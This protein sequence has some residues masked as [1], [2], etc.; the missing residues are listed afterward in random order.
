MTAGELSRMLAARADSV[1]RELLPN[2]K[3]DGREW[4]VGSVNGEAGQS[5]GVCIKGDKAGTWK[6]FNTGDGGDLLDLIRAAQGVDLPQACDIARA[7]LGLPSEKLLREPKK[8]YSR[9]KRPKCQAPKSVVKEYLASRGISE[10]TMAAYK[11]GEQGNRMVF[12]F[13]R[14]GELIMAKTREAV[15]GGKTKPTEANCEPCLFGWQAV[16]AKSR[17]LIITEGEIDALSVR[18]MGFPALSVPYGGGGGD[19]QGWIEHEFERLSA[20]DSLYLMLDNDET[21]DQGVAEIVKRLGRDRIRIVRIP[22]PYKDANDLLTKARFSEVDMANLLMRA[23]TLDPAELRAASSYRDQVLGEVEA[24]EA[25]GFDLPWPKTHDTFRMRFGESIIV[26]GVNG[27]GKTELVGNIALSV[28]SQNNRACIASYEFKPQRYLRRFLRQAAAMENPSTPLMSA[29]FDW[30]DDKL[31]MVDAHGKDR[32]QKTLEVF[33][34][35]ARR[36]GVRFFVLDNLS[37][38]GI[39]DDDYQAQKEFIDELSELA[40]E[41]DVVVIIVM[42]MT[43]GDESRPSGKMQARGSGQIT[44]LVDS[45]L[46]VWRNKPKEKAMQVGDHEKS[47]EPDCK[48][49]CEKQRNGEHETAYKLWFDQP[50]HQFKEHPKQF[51]KRYVSIAA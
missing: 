9:P 35:A 46:I 43:K 33:R 12:P 38:C 7:M 16:P 5:L 6:D 15:D 49:I 23:E 40:R 34:Y 20:Y 51:V 36:Y 11:I 13:L 8:N 18:E 26:A 32:A 29:G 41:M 10:A 27:H 45:L 48:L 2:G 21:G 17:D 42:H 37:K 1:A 31:W 50:S 22:K 4:R 44:D 19:K 28:I 24:G 47:D 25:P 3:P 39:A 30:L 14:D